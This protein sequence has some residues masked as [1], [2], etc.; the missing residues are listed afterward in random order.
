MVAREPAATTS[1]LPAAPDAP[2]AR[3]QRSVAPRP[4]RPMLF[5]VDKTQCCND[6]KDCLRSDAGRGVGVATGWKLT[7]AVDRESTANVFKRVGL[8]A[9]GHTWIK[10]SDD[11]G[12]VWSYG[13][14][15]QTGF[16]T[17]HPFTP[18]KGCVHHP[19]VAHEPP[20]ATDYKE[21]TYSV[22]EAN[23]QKALDYAQDQCKSFPDYN[24]ASYNCTTFAIEAAQAAG[25][26]PPASTTLGVHDPNALYE[27]IE[28]EEAKTIQGRKRAVAQANP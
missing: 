12:T 21:F 9:V 11:T 22:T 27:G 14:W 10:F 5:R 26:A 25:V 3:L 6:W 24:L 15:P 2:R 1:E 8:G 28:A 20:K 13:M 4:T 16:D 18:V 17:K 7:I 19:D 23:F